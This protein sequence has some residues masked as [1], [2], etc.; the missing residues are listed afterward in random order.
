MY[1]AFGYGKRCLVTDCSLV[2]VRGIGGGNA[3][4]HDTRADD[5]NP[6]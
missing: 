3:R 5:R 2:V 4:T 6:A 1:Y